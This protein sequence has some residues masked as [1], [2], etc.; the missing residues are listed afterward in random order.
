MIGF[1]S[2]TSG[3]FGSIGSGSTPPP[4]KLYG[5]FHDTITRSISLNSPTPIRLNSTDS[6]A[7]YGVTIQNDLSGNPTKIVV[8]QTGVYNLQ[9]SS[10]VQKTSG[11][12]SEILTIWINVNGSPIPNTSTN[13]TLANNSQLLVVAWNFFVY[14]TSGQYVQLMASATSNT[15]VLQ[16]LPES[17][18]VPYPAVPSTILTIA[19]I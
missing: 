8:T 11:G 7:T 4:T 14:L 16:Y 12:G 10:Q 19:Q 6:S 17:L 9:F 3:F 13:V 5:S 15:I 2:R 1:G 18:I